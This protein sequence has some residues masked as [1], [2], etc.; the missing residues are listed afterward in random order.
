MEVSALSILLLPA[1][2]PMNRKVQQKIKMCV[3]GG[4]MT[5]IS[6]RG[7]VVFAEAQVLDVTLMN[8]GCGKPLNSAMW[9]QARS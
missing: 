6:S 3:C 9:K 8:S 5:L 4:E 2:H 1:V 7:G